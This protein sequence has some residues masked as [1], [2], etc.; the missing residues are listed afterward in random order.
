MSYLEKLSEFYDQNEDKLETVFYGTAKPKDENLKRFYQNVYAKKWKSDWKLAKQLYDY[1]NANRSTIN[2]SLA[3][4]NTTHSHSESSEYHLRESH[5]FFEQVGDDD[6]EL[7]YEFDAV[8][9]EDMAKTQKITFQRAKTNTNPN[10]RPGRS[11]LPDDDPVVTT[12]LDDEILELIP[13]NARNK[14]KALTMGFTGYR[15]WQHFIPTPYKFNFYDKNQGKKH[16]NRPGTWM[17]D[18]MYFSNYGRKNI[19]DKE[20]PLRY[21]Q[22]IYLVG[23]NVNT[24]YVVGRRVE[25]KS[26]DDLIPP[27]KDLLENELR[28]KINLLIFDGE[29]AISSKKFEEFCREKRINVKIT[30]PGIHTQTAPIDRLC[31][32]LRDYYSKMYLSKMQQGSEYNIPNIIREYKKFPFRNEK[33]FKEKMNTEA[34]Y[35]RQMFNG[36]HKTLLPP[37]PRKY[38][39]FGDPISGYNDDFNMESGDYRTIIYEDPNFPKFFKERFFTVNCSDE[40]LDV[41]NYYNNKPHNGLIRI[42]KQAEE[43]FH[44][45]L[46]LENVTPNDVNNNPQLEKIIIEYCND[47]NRNVVETGPEYKIGDKVIVYDCFTK[48]RG[49]LRRNEKTPL[50]GNWE[51]VSKENEIY[52]VKNKNNNQ[53]LHV[54]KYMLKHK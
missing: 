26:V 12:Y 46:N 9:P 39:F 35:V 1:L 15:Y 30:Y 18:L 2:R 11:I 19:K 7:S 31:R 16:V 5:S 3:Q 53:L 28:G 43:L 14:K 27:F 13:S 42:F 40:L 10:L 36:D 23:I 6:S 41:I 47:Y 45:K 20:S 25:G 38:I 8:Y 50:M 44:L 49:N 29:K 52:G 34:L 33:V 48:D 37:I 51:I 24:R 21:Q 4:I 32:T 54:S 22:A 17:F